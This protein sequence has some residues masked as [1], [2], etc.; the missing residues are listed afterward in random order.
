MWVTESDLTDA[1]FQLLVGDHLA[2]LPAHGQV[3]EVSEKLV[4]VIDQLDEHPAPRTL[5]R[6]LERAWPVGIPAGCGCWWR[7]G[8]PTIRSS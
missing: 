7:A 8:P 4:V 1:E 5:V 3:N 6:R 2:A